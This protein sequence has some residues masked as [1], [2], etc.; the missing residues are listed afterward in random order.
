M[1]TTEKIKNLTLY[2]CPSGVGVIFVDLVKSGALD[3]YAD[4]VDVVPWESPDQLR[5]GIMDN[6]IDITF[7]PSYAGAHFYNKGIEFKLLNIMTNGLL[8]VI[9]SDT[10]IANI[11]DLKGKEIVV[12]FPNEMPNLVLQVLLKKAGLNIGTDVI[13]KDVATPAVAAKRAITGE[14]DIV[15]LPEIAA[16]KVSIMA[17]EK[18]NADM[19]HVI[20]IQ[21]EWG[22]LLN[23]KPSIPLAG[24]AVRAGFADAHPELLKTLHNAMVTSAEAL[25]NDKD[26]LASMAE[27]LWKGESP[28][29]VKSIDKW[30]LCLRTAADARADLESFYTILKD[31]NPEIIGGKLP[32]DGFYWAV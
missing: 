30:N 28:V 19:R 20:D 3:A 12:P 2:C 29:F 14:A 18:R 24:V 15:L 8:Y 31:L 27:V 32:D 22:R 25:L 17:K 1:N 21:K 23:I 5:A 13:V 7:V 26:R 11:E 9:S 10:G 6:S 16:T 4:T